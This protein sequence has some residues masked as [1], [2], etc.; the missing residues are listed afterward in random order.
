[1]FIFYVKCFI[2]NY[3]K[4]ANEEYYSGSTELVKAYWRGDHLERGKLQQLTASKSN[5][6][7][8]A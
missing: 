6:L 4:S 1:M 8:F 7:S 3:I 2:S 5:S